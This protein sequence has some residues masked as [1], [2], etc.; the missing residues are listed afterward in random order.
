ME[1]QMESPVKII[2][3]V[4]IPDRLK[5]E[6]YK[7][8]PELGPQILFFSGG[9]AIR[10][11]SQQLINY[12][13]NSIHLI[14]PFDYGGSSRKLRDA[15]H[16]IS[17][18]DLRNRL[19]ALADQSHK[20][21]PNIYRLF[22]YRLPQDA[23]NDRLK[24]RLKNMAE[25]IDPLT[26][27]IP[28]PMKS[29]ICNHLR[30]FNKEMPADFDLQG[31]NIGNLILVGGYLY[32][33]YNIDTVVYIFS[34]LIEARG[35]VK[36]LMTRLL[37][38]V[39]ELEDGTLLVGQ[40]LITGK[41]YPA[42]TFPV[43][44]LYLTDSLDKPEPVRVEIEDDIKSLIGQADLICYPMGSFYS[45]IVANLLPYGVEEAVALNI[46][47]KVYIPN[48]T[49]DPEQT[50]MDLFRSVGTIITNLKKNRLDIANT[51]LLNYVL[52]DSQ[53]AKYPYSTSASKLAKLGVEIIDTRLVTP[54]SSPYI[55]SECL[56]DVLLSLT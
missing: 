36:P 39:A 21:N 41:E 47:P 32:S 3:S 53:N 44:N 56:I 4:S 23:S 5:I 38:L 20:G 22:V 7:R 2:R 19:M 13:Y 31:A 37:H 6:R 43:K 1:D 30:W 51:D 27:S 16:M 35:T 10:S 45:S 9:S 14:T 48:T 50:G 8:L 52:I 11:L 26:D 49:S 34:K 42:I 55:D 15:F 28:E 24:A 12:T 33:N 29:I 17:V 46:C 25:G 54:R 40:H 18:G